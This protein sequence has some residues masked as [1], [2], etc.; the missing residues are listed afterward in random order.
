MEFKTITGWI[1]PGFS[2]FFAGL[3]GVQEKLTCDIKE[4]YKNKIR[5]PGGG[6][7]QRLITRIQLEI[8]FHYAPVEQ[9][10]HIES[11]LGD[12][13]SDVSQRE[14]CAFPRD[15]LRRGRCVPGNIRVSREVAK[16]RKGALIPERKED[17]VVTQVQSVGRTPANAINTSD[18]FL[19]TLAEGAPSRTTLNVKR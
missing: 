17:R 10:H 1:F 15:F 16:T 5:F 4:E 13:C 6:K 12:L 19:R 9:H 8:H 3:R 11:R 7:V 18:L 14:R 2:R